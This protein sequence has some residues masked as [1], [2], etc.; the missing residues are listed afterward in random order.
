MDEKVAWGL[1]GVLIGGFIASLVIGW[2]YFPDCWKTSS[3]E[4]GWQYSE[5]VEQDSLDCSLYAYTF[6]SKEIAEQ[7]FKENNYSTSK[8]LGK[9]TNPSRYSYWVSFCWFDPLGYTEKIGVVS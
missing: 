5:S 6:E 7:Y 3:C 9:T 2:I 8:Y 1:I 4:D